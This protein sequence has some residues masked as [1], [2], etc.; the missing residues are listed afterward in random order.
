MAYFGPAS[1]ARQYFINLGFLDLPRQTSGDWLCGITWEA[2][3]VEWLG[4]LQFQLAF[5]SDP[6]S[7]RIPSNCL[8]R[9]RS[10]PNLAA[11]SRFQPGRDSSNVPSTPE[12]LAEAYRNSEIRQRMIKEMEDYKAQL[13]KDRS[14]EEEFRAAVKEDKNKGVSK[15]SIYTISFFGQVQ[16]LFTRQM[17]M[18]WGNKFDIVMSY[19]TSIVMAII[20][21]STFLQLPQT[22]AGGEWRESGKKSSRVFDSQ[23]SFFFFVL[24]RSFHSRR[25]LVHLFALQ[26]SVLAL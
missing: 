4:L 3:A 15:K 21:G 24:I 22:A 5:A 9:L 7:S 2:I 26:W 12:S 16:V 20:I 19:L 14:I 18:V 17:Q 8:S 25:S 1:E 11:E 6:F 23:W 13:A 10:D